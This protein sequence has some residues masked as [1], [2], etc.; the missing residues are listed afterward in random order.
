MSRILGVDYGARRIG[1]AIS[2]DSKITARPLAVVRRSKLAAEL[3]EA[4]ADYDIEMV[5]M[6]LPT[7]LAGNEGESAREARLLADE[8]GS[9]LGVEVHFVDE[10]FT[11]RIAE[12]SLLQAGMK[13][14]DRR[15]TVD[16]VAAALILQSY[17]DYGHGRNQVRGVDVEP[18]ESHDL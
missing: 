4:I 15:E 10:R 2:D 9:L 17:L 1:L 14:R 5:V 12:Q 6:G 13:R 16:R 3:E 7:G 11:T 18:P 8:I